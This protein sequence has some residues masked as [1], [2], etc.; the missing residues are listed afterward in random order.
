M[1]QTARLRYSPP[2]PYKGD[3]SRP[4]LLTMNGQ[5]IDCVPAKKSYRTDSRPTVLHE[6]GISRVQSPSALHADEAKFERLVKSWQR[7]TAVHS[8]VMKIVMH[9]AYQQMIG[10]G[11]TALPFIFARLKAEQEEPDHWFW[12]LAAITE[13][14]PVPKESRGRLAEMADA[15]LRWGSENKYVNLD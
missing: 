15:W 7:Q 3:W 12:A 2:E 4:R 6:I 5:R 10:M 9:P 8:S 13:E 11:K 14:N 1:A